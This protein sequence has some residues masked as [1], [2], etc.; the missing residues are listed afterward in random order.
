M[1]KRVFPIILLLILGACSLEKADSEKNHDISSYEEFPLENVIDGD[2]IKIRYHGAVESVRFLLV[3]T[4]ET[5]HP[6]HGEQP[7]GQEA[8]AFTKELLAGYETI[9]LEFDVSYRDKY[10]RLLAYVYTADGKNVQEELLKNG[11]ARVAYIYEPNT[12]H[13]DWFDAIQTAAKEE[14]VGIW[15][16]ENYAQEDGFHPESFE[17]SSKANASND[18]LIKG[19][20]GS[21][22]IYHT[23]VSP[24]YEQTK[25]E[26]MFCTEKEAVDAGF[27]P[28]KQ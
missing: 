18:C 15:S 19:N 26:V 7:F 10:N 20:I 3:D 9:Y 6:T 2:T 4:P 14:A 13:V 5:N 24:S 16:V 8:K 21:N 28:P 17:H 22:K 25:A 1:L 23:P 11:L 12:K 27:R